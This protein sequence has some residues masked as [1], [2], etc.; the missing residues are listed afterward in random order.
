MPP[1]SSGAYPDR[2]PLARRRA[3]GRAGGVACKGRLNFLSAGHAYANGSAVCGLL[4][5]LPGLWPL[6]TAM[7]IS[8]TLY[9]RAKCVG[10]YR[11]GQ[12]SHRSSDE[13]VA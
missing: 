1:P 5:A 2:V 7:W 4:V 10:Y 13:S 12:D 3:A 6:A 8:Y 9:L 11:Q